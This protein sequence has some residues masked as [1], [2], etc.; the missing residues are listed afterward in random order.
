LSSSLLVKASG[1]RLSASPAP[2]PHGIA[3][4]ATATAATAAAFVIISEL[5]D[6]VTLT[7]LVSSFGCAGDHEGH[8]G[9]G[10]QDGQKHNTTLSRVHDLMSLKKLAFTKEKFFLSINFW[11]LG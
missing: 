1:L 10:H 9:D 6:N 4:E 7:V 11:L 5:D 8:D 3:T 2:A